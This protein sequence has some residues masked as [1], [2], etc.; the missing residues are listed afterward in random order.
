MMQNNDI[1]KAAGTDNLFLRDEAEILAQPISVICNLS[2]T[3]RTFPKACKVA[4]L[5]P[6]F[7]KSQKTDT[8]NYR[9][10]LFLP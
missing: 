10:I 2:I 3:S 5:K 1:S 7:K 6:V 8:S 9:T 4:R